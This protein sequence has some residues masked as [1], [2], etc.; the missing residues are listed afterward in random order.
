MSRSRPGVPYHHN[1]A[2]V[3][4]PAWVYLKRS[5]GLK[6][7]VQYV[8]EEDAGAQSSQGRARLIFG[9]G[10]LTRIGK[11]KADSWEFLEKILLIGKMTKGL[12]TFKTYLGTR[13]VIC[14]V[15]LVLIGTCVEGGYDLG[16]RAP[17]T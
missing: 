17:G 5:Q 1:D 8:E 2:H 11:K 4:R 14:L 3:S 12:N 9:G 10:K 16:P 6:L 13:K 7:Q 15:F